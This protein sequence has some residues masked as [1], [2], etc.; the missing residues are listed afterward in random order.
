MDL[1]QSSIPD[2]VTVFRQKSASLLSLW[3]VLFLT[4]FLSL[5]CLQGGFQG[6]SLPTRRWPSLVVVTTDFSVTL[7]FSPPAAHRAIWYSPS[8]RLIY[9]AYSQKKKKWKSKMCIYSI[10]APHQNSTCMVFVAPPHVVFKV[11]I[12]ADP[13]TVYE[14]KQRWQRLEER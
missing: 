14:Q 11:C 3:R 8:K 12:Y 6:C 2:S 10:N 1:G 7:A 13:C 4:R 9:R 5:R